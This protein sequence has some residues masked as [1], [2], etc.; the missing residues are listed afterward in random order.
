V[1]KKQENEFNTELHRLI[2]RYA[3]AKMDMNI[4]ASLLV[5]YAEQ[6]DAALFQAEADKIVAKSLRVAG[7]LS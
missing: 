1:S 5:A 2:E 6:I 7:R 4:V 3:N